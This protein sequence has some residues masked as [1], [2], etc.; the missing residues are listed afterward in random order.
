MEDMVTNRQLVD[1][2]VFRD[3]DFL[4]NIRGS[5]ERTCCERMKEIFKVGLKALLK[6]P[7]LVAVALTTAVAPI[8]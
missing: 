8:G 4:G 5:T 1:C 6:D 7:N 2:T 3:K